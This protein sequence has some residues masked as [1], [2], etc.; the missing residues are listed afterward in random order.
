MYSVSQYPRTPKSL[1]R[2]S[3]LSGLCPAF[4]KLDHYENR[5]EFKN[6]TDLESTLRSLF[7]KH[8]N[9]TIIE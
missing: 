3:L 9:E 2:R 1:T 5:T 7:Q 8:R 4:D 6:N